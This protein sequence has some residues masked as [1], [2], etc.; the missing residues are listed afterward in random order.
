VDLNHRPQHYESCLF[1]AFKD[2]LFCSKIPYLALN[3]F[4]SL[5]YIYK[6]KSISA[7]LVGFSKT[8]FR[9]ALII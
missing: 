7:F 6:I 5:I 4:K 8:L 9:A 3:L 2:I 1:D